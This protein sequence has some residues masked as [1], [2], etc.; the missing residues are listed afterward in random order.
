MRDLTISRSCGCF[1]VPSRDVRGLY[2][3]AVAKHIYLIIVGGR[4]H[5]PE[6]FNEKIS[7]LLSLES[8]MLYRNF[9]KVSSNSIVVDREGIEQQGCAIVKDINI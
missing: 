3:D 1:M 5:P 9:G 2:P 8:R 7:K 6:D 4:K